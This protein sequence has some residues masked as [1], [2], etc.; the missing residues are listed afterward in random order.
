MKY[1]YYL[2]LALLWSCGPDEP[3][4]A[5]RPNILFCIADDA[6]FLHMGAYGT[7]WVT[8]PAFD[9]VA[10]EGLLFQRAYTP[11]AK[12]A[13]SRACILTGRNS[14]QL[15][16]AANHSPTFPAKFTSFVE[17]LGENGYRTGFTGKGWAPGDPGTVA[18][19][20]R[21]LTG[22]PYQEQ[23]ATPPTAAMSDIDYAANFTAFLDAAPAT[24]PF[25]FWY[26]G[27]EPHRAYTYGSG[28]DG[29][30]RSLDDLDSVPP[31]WPDTDTV[32]TDLLDY[33]REIDHFDDHLGRMLAELERRGELDN[34]IVVVT[35]DNG[36]P[37][38]R[39]KGQAY[40]M[41]N[42]LP[43]AVRW[44]AGIVDAGRTIKDFV[45]FV[46]LAPTFLDIAGVAWDGSEMSPTV[47]Q[48]LRPILENTQDG[49]FRDHVLIGKER[50]DVGRPGDVGYPIRGIV[51][52]DYLYLRNYATDRWP[53]GN[54]E[55]G[56]LNTDGSPTKTT[57]L[58]GRRN[59]TD[60]SGLWQLNFGKRPA[61]E[62]YNIAA[63]PYCVNNLA[64]D[65]ELATLIAGIEEEMITE[66]R[67][68]GDPRVMGNGKVFDRYPY[69]GAVAGFYE[70]YMG[71]E[72][73]EASWVEESDFEPAPLDDTVLQASRLTAE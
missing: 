29:T 69:S 57:L 54:P 56:Y 73:V 2:L 17:V 3:E 4:L 52:G 72:A 16:E 10:R 35:A 62:V 30:G 22:T 45:N 43:L 40:E 8:T 19:K 34:T 63:D 27:Y 1:V 39:I 44:P 5:N 65:P 33:A 24:A 32:R 38:P 13:P 23:H 18:G 70:R 68:Q 51:R 60:T 12:C 64:D 49:A 36:M 50:H 7:D 21:Q 55:T 42:H 15:E 46:D 26:G 53:V 59:G 28:L 58:N 61:V 71:G 31:M 9:R 48:T 14:W 25:F 47:G 6:S 20:R 37:F 11:N 66:L 67:A 41:S